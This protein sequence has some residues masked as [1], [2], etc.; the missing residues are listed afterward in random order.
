MSK[1]KYNASER[2]ETFNKMVYLESHILYIF[3]RINIREYDIE[4][5]KI[6]I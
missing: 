3:C 1:I 4:Q 2:I 6:I 5:R